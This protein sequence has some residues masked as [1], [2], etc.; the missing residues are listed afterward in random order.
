MLNSQYVA[1]NQKLPD[2]TKP[3]KIGAMMNLKINQL[4][5]TQN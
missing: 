4:K 5:L 2:M 1:S 3:G